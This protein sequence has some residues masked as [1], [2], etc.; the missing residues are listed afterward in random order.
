MKV[1]LISLNMSIWIIVRTSVEFPD[2]DE[3]PDYEQLQ[4]IHRITQASSMLL[5][6]LDLEKAKDIWDTLQKAHEGIK[7]VKKVKR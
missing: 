1:H 7:P 2:E 5:Y 4:Q 3:E 6:S